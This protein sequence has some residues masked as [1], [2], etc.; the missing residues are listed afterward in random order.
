MSRQAYKGEKRYIGMT[1]NRRDTEA[2]V[3][4]S[5]TYEIRNAAG[6]VVQSGGASI[7]GAEVF[8]LFD[9]TPEAIVADGNYSHFFITLH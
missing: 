2:V 9:T 3:V 8:C 5:A 1:V 6:T 7:D 4:A